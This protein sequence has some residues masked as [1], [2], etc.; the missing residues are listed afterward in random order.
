[1][2]KQQ[3]SSKILIVQSDHSAA[4][5]LEERLKNLGYTVCATPS[6]GQ[7]AIEKAATMHPDLALI[8]LELKGDITGIDVAEQIGSR[9]PVIFLMDEVEEDQLQQ[10]QATRPFGYV[11]KPYEER[12]LHLNIQTAL[13]MH[14]REKKQ[15]E[16][17]NELSD[18][19]QLTEA[20][21]D[22]MGDGVIVTDEHRKTLLWNS[23]AAQIGGVN[24][25][26]YHTDQWVKKY[27]FFLPDRETPLTPETSPL[28][29]AIKGEAIDNVEVFI[30]NAQKPDGVY[31]NVSGRP[32]LREGG[33]S[34]GAVL[35]IRDITEYKKTEARLNQTLEKLRNQNELL[36]TT[37]NS[38]R[39][40]IVVANEVGEFLYVN[41]GA[42][43]IIG[44]GATDTPQDK[45]SE[46]YGSF[47]LDQKTLIKTEDLPLLRAIY[48]G[49]VT[50]DEDIF[51][52]NAQRPDGV[53]IRVSGRPLLNEIGGIRGGVITFRDVTEQV[54]AEEA[55]AQAFAQGRLEIVDTILH[56]IGNAINSVTVGIETVHQNLINDPFLHRLCAL[57]D[58]IKAHRDNWVDYIRNDP[59]GQ[60]VI[61]FVIALAEDF[62]GLNERLVKTVARV[63]DRADYI[64]DIVRTQKAFGSPSMDQKDIHLMDAFSS[65]ITVLQ[66]SVD[67]REIETVIDCE[68]APQEIRIQE[69]Q[70]H[71]MMVNLIKNSIEAIDDL[72][73][74]DKIEETP[75]IQIRAYIEGN[76]LYLDVRDNG[77]GIEQTNLKKIFSAGYTTKKTGSG[78][79][80][81][82]AA[83]FVIG[84]GGKIHALSDGIGKGTTLRIMLR[85][86]AITPQE[87]KDTDE[88]TA[89]ETQ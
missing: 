59:Q 75:R 42:E 29:R 21:F 65:A 88:R 62:T 35:I 16:T 70:F 68:N 15:R 8:D 2:T 4:T 51:I 24:I 80:L 61:P 67:K 22:S 74:S 50:E 46:K 5:H 39:E 54:N 63:K 71:Q 3:S 49:E 31:T 11:L 17:E 64:A 48:K 66:E 56:N 53:Y 23:K 81:H 73:A 1:M 47:Y 30:R 86:S 36:E 20:I 43:K 76:F 41:P 87:S 82:S 44:M 38:I 27:G 83:N 13:S 60:K 52:R 45:W 37:F 58:A 57:A 12:Q 84:S 28:R 6:S 78:L 85:L 34:R 18:Q 14:E 33:I 26:T 19:I 55:L 72:A 79:G 69:S 89:N 25:P 77:I 7:Q 9:M 10:A 32:L 40:G